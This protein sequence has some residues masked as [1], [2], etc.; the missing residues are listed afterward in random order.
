MITENR[1][2]P[3]A[4]TD[5]FRMESRFR[6]LLPWIIAGG[7]FLIYLA[8]LN[9]WVT[10]SS[11]PNVARV[12]GWNWQPEIWPFTQPQPAP[13]YWLLTYPFRWLPVSTIPVALNLLSVL[14][15][16]LSLALLARSVTLLPHDRTNAQ[17]LREKSESALLSMRSAWLPPVLA[18]VVCGLQLSFWEHA[19]AASQDMLNLLLFAF[20]IRCLLE[21][22]VDGRHCWLSRA[23]FVYGL[24]ITNDWAFIGFFPVFIA[25][26]VWIKG[27]SF[28]DLGFLGRMCLWGCLGLLCYLLLPLI[29]SLSTISPVP[30]WT[31]LR[32]NLG[33]QKLLLATVLNKHMLI[34]ADKPFWVLGIASLLPLLMLSI[35][36]PSFSGDTSRLGVAIASFSF[37]LVY[38][39]LLLLCVWIALDP[40]MSPRFHVPEG[41]R[42]YLP[43]L[44]LYYLGALGV[45]Y[46]C[47]YFLL[48]LGKKVERQRRSSSRSSS[49]GI[50]QVGGVGVLLIVTA[51]LVCRNLPQM[52]TTNGPSLKDFTQLLTENFPSEPAVILSDDIRKLL[53]AQ[54]LTTQQG[55]SSKYVF[56]DT[57]SLKW[58]DYHR[59][60]KRHYGGRW[61]P[62]T[63]TTEQERALDD[64]GVLQLIWSL[65]E[66]NTLYY[67]H[68]SF[69]YYF[70]RFYLEPHG[71]AYKLQ[72]YPA[73][74]LLA[75]PL[76]PEITAENEAFWQQAQTGLLTRLKPLV[77]ASHDK[78]RSTW[79]DKVFARAHL[80]NEPNREMSVIA[81]FFSRALNFWGVE[82]QKQKRLPEAAAHFERAL[83]V[84]RD[85]L[86]AS[87]NLECNKNLQA[88]HTPSAKL[89]KSIEDQFG[90]YR[91]W[92]QIM[93]A[94]GPFDQPDFCFEQGRLFG[95]LGLYHQA[96]QEFDRAVALEP[97]NVSARLMLAQIYLLNQMPDRAGGLVEEIHA[98][99]PALSLSRSNQ[100]NLL[101][102]EMTVHLIKGELAPA[103][104]AFQEAITRFPKDEELLATAAQVFMT[105]GYYTNA[106]TAIDAQ[107][108]IAPDNTSALVN[109]GYAF[110]QAQDFEKA[111][112]FF[113]KALALEPGHTSALF[114]RAI[115]FVRLKKANQAKADYQQ[116]QKSYPTEFR[117]D[118]GLAQVAL[119]EGD[120]NAA[121]RYFELYLTHSP[122][123]NVEEPKLVRAQ[124][125]ELKA[126]AH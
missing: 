115:C 76:G 61:Q 53:L 45:G 40:P 72:R 90:K 21:F 8:T 3:A 116:L 67:L 30:F 82:A 93:N 70:E 69:G 92:D 111:I 71:L 113:S 99:P 47:G 106:L 104:R 4:D 54:E 11:I 78:T 36:W 64:G 7:A 66:S 102:I 96:A 60:L 52:R 97:H 84:N 85:N 46:F 74:G 55:R 121:I 16:A 109:K 87:I 119:L 103:E 75:P 88:G 125:E 13:V 48:I 39:I 28:F 81:E 83:E 118:F 62:G 33:G 123:S 100:A 50:V 59:F 95:R 20:V 89:P 2:S 17:R 80:V 120:T 117:I 58:P 14:L 122:P 27:L 63:Q 35:P 77:A 65:S 29:Q 124:L 12:S 42:P 73:E 56:L 98:L 107:L 114:N 91:K 18:V 110:M 1:R 86:V 79:M 105:A 15:A 49:E 112:G 9:H 94:N 22:R 25:A 101:H 10:F 41:L 31:A 19:T 24:G 5:V 43:M 37:H 38:G 6:G 68:P 126:G 108:L 44:T 32:A 51:L 26:V 34:H 23:A 57:S